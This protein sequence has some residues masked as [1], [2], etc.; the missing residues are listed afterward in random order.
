METSR[1][2][3]IALV[4][5]VFSSQKRISGAEVE[6]RV[7]PGDDVTLFCDCVWKVGFYP[8]WFR[9]CSEEDHPTVKI[10]LADLIDGDVLGGDFKRYSFVLNDSTNT[11][12]LLIKN[13]T[14]SDQGLYYC[15][16]SEK[17]YQD[18]NKDVTSPLDVYCYGN[19]SS[20][21]SVLAEPCHSVSEESVSCVSW[22]LVFSVCVV[23]VL[24]SSLL[25][26]ICVYCV[27]TNTTKARVK[28]DLTGS[29]KRTTLRREKVGDDEVCYAS[30]DTQK[31]ERKKMKRKKRIQH[32]DFS[33]YSEKLLRLTVSMR[34]LGKC[35]D[36]FLSDKNSISST[37]KQVEVWLKKIDKSGLPGKYKC[38]I[39]QHGLLVGLRGLRKAA[40]RKLGE[41]VADMDCRRRSS[42][43]SR[44]HS[45]TIRES[46]RDF[47]PSSHCPQSFC[48]PEMEPPTERRRPGNLSALRPMDKH[49]QTKVDLTLVPQYNKL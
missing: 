20:R 39:Y 40:V 9:N 32:S 11:Q 1:V 13:I 38:W 47:C 37:G 7:R 10:S 43:Q 19:R 16:L 41:D 31:L 12:D 4:C 49:M 3:L 21:L 30:L 25:S 5:V 22:S 2:A 44:G 24:L 27:C 33:T 36:D 46:R 8:M 17:L 48:Q 26:S 28:A 18:H 14:E 23:C 34:Y 6:M 42:L 35:Y 45:L 15:A 29:D